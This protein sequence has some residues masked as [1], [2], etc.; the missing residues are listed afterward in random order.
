MTW[1]AGWDYLSKAS[2]DGRAPILRTLMFCSVGRDSYIWFIWSGIGC[3]VLLLVFEI[4]ERNARRKKQRNGSQP[5]SKDKLVTASKKA[6]LRTAN[7]SKKVIR[8][9]ANSGYCLTL[10]DQLVGPHH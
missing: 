5:L 2:M 7:A 6:D 9:G 1:W 10:F 3:L 4:I 8:F